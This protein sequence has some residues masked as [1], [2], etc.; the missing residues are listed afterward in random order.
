MGYKWMWGFLKMV[1]KLTDTQKWNRKE[2]Y[3]Y[4]ESVEAISGPLKKEKKTK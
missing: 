3:D 1:F 2:V 4:M